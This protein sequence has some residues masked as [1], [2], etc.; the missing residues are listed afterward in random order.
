MSQEEG[1][2]FTVIKFETGDI[3]TNF[4]SIFD[5]YVLMSQIGIDFVLWPAY[6]SMSALQMCPFFSWRICS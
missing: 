2:V 5:Y 1:K 6:Y 4:F 3:D